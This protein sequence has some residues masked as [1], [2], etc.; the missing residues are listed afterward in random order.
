MMVKQQKIAWILAAVVAATA[1]WIGCNADPGTSEEQVLYRW[2]TEDAATSGE[3]GSVQ[4]NEIGWAGSVDD[5][6]NYYPDDVF[7]E[8]RNEYHRPVNLSGWRI[9]L[10]GDYQRSFR[11]PRIERPLQPNAQFVIAA[12]EDGA[13][14]NV[15]T[16]YQEIDEEG[17]ESDEMF[18]VVDDRLQL[19]HRAV[20]IT[21]RDADR[22]LIDSGGSSTDRPFAGG[23]DGV[24]VRSMERTQSL[25]DNNGGMDRSWTSNIDDVDPR[26]IGTEHYE[27]GRENI[28]EGF[29]KYTLASPGEPNSADYAG[30]SAG[31][32]AE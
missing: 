8:L 18:G 23:Y 9:K 26:L 25:F 11:L 28:A 32:Q 14:G 4:I 5:D 20:R 16:E 30:A 21:L 3:R 22:R 6:G 19:G 17:E 31:G 15:T 2:D 29:Q 27:G 1:V 13:F 24:T 12:K 10:D 7:I